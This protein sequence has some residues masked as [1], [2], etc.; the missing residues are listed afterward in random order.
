MESLN[1]ILNRV[2]WCW[3]RYRTWPLS[4][5]NGRS[6]PTYVVCLECGAELPYA[7]S[8]DRSRGFTS[9][10]GLLSRDR[11]GSGEAER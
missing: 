4:R 7:P 8:D 11:G 3:H 10:V 2:S 9:M 6:V 5:L 1:A